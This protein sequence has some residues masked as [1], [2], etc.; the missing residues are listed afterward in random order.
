MKLIP[1]FALG[2]CIDPTWKDQPKT[3]VGS[4]FPPLAEWYVF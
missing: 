3:H 4:G 1:S 2:V